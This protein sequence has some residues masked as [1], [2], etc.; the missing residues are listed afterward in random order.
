M[1]QLPPVKPGDKMF[2]A[3]QALSEAVQQHPNKSRAQL[4]D[5]IVIKFDLSPKECEFLQKQFA[6]DET[7]K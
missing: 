7:S 5:A 3:L 2:N 4:L 6:L 1:S